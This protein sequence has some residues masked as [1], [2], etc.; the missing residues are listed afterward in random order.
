MISERQLLILLGVELQYR[1]DVDVQL[2]AV[3]NIRRPSRQRVCGPIDP[4]G[5]L[6]VSIGND[7]AET[8]H[9]MHQYM[10]AIFNAACHLA[11]H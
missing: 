9:A 4:Y 5:M 11:W 6:Q 7:M 10:A 3:L 1:A 2:G 8:I